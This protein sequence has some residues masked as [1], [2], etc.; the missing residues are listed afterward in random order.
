MALEREARRGIREG[1]DR[2]AEGLGDPLIGEELGVRREALAQGEPQLGGAGG[3]V[4]EVRPRALGVHVIRRQRRDPAPVVGAGAREHLE[5]DDV[6]QVRRHLDP[7]ARPEHEPRDG[8]RRDELG[9]LR[10]GRVLHRRARLRAEVLHDHFL[11]VPVALVG[12]AQ[13]D[14]RLR[15]VAQRLANAHED[16]R[17]ERDLRAPRVVE[18]LQ[19]HRRILVGGPVVHL[20]LVLVQSA[21]G[22]LEHHAHRRGD[23]AQAGELVGVHDAGVEVREQARLLADQACDVTDVVER[24]REAVLVEPGARLGPAIL[25]PVAEREQGLLAAERLALPRD[26][27]HLLFAHVR[28]LALRQQLTGG[29]DEHA[30]VAAIAAQGRQ[31]QEHLARVGDDSL[32]PG[33]AQAL[34]AN[35]GGRVEQPLQVGPRRT[36]QRLGVIGRQALAPF[37]AFEGGI[38]RGH[39]SQSS[40]SEQQRGVLVNESHE[41]VVSWRRNVELLP[42]CGAREGP[43]VPG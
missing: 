13:G 33:K 19:A 29:V 23:V 1:R 24:R 16:P 41:L 5:L 30:V 36:E 38:R 34:V 32:A 2:L 9:E 6:L 11:D 15:A 12:V 26:R 8:D 31:G 27:Q 4:V 37:G 14:H 10:V 17:R 40:T 39:Q 42:S 21:R 28:R 18:Q 7:H 3:E 35:G 22:R 25:G 43:K 20:A